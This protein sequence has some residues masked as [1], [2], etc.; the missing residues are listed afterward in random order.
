VGL[1]DAPAPG[2]AAVF[3]RTLKS[4]VAAMCGES[5]YVVGILA[6]GVI[7]SPEQMMLDLDIGAGHHQ[8]LNVF[9][10]DD[11]STAVPL[12]RERGIR[13]F[14]MDTEHTAQNFRKRIWRPKTF[15]RQKTKD[16][17]TM[18]DPVKKAYERW[19]QIVAKTEPYH[20]PEENMRE[21]DKI[22]ARAEQE[23]LSR[24]C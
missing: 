15:E 4:T 10:G 20:L 19:T 7:F 3:E 22:L 21:I 23:I 6:G 16:P 8:F 5:T 9:D 12:I 11:L 1:I 13:G 18:A 14:F 24:A 2:P 17:K